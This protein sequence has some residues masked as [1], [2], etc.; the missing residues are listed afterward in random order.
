MQNIWKAVVRFPMEF[1]RTRIWPSRK[2]WIRIRPSRKKPDPIPGW[3]KRIWIKHNFTRLHF[4]SLSNQILI[5]RQ[6]NRIH[7]PAIGKLYTKKLG[8]WRF[9]GIFHILYSFCTV[10]YWGGEGWLSRHYISSVIFHLSQ[11]KKKQVTSSE[12]LLLASYSAPIWIFQIYHL[13]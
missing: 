5:D 9:V 13:F 10:A 2:N 8:T 1:T 12:N 7:N 4:F 6:K 3:K 11:A